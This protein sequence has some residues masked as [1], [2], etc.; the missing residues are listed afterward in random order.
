MLPSGFPVGLLIGAAL[1]GLAILFTA[2]LLI[3]WLRMRRA[4]GGPE[5]PDPG[6]EAPR[7]ALAP[8]PFQMTELLVAL[9]DL[10]T[11]RFSHQTEIMLESETRI[12]SE[13]TELQCKIDILADRI[14]QGEK[15]LGVIEALLRDILQIL[16]ISISESKTL[17]QKL[18]KHLEDTGKSPLQPSAQRLN[19]LR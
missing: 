9:D 15:E 16:N 1:L 4:G 17:S 2:G 3:Q 13:L 11:K 14:R 5:N 19:Q 6:D 12:R 18:Q 8:P 7:P 10:L